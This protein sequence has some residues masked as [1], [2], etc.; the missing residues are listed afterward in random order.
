MEK[1][2]CSTNRKQQIIEHQCG[3]PNGKEDKRRY[4]N[5]LATIINLDLTGYVVLQTSTSSFT[6][7]TENSLLPWRP[8]FP[9]TDPQ[10]WFKTHGFGVHFSAPRQTSGL[11]RTTT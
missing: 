5:H 8:S 6:T 3:S 1:T 10:L 7:L 4:S 11:I 9:K 2:C